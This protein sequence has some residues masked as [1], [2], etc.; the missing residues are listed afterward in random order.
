MKN[1]LLRGNAI[2][3][4]YRYFGFLGISVFFS[5][6]ITLSSSNITPDIRDKEIIKKYQAILLDDPSNLNAHFN[7]GILYYKN[8][9]FDEATREFKKVLEINPNDA[10]AY[11]NLGNSYNKKAQYDDA[12]K[13]YKKSLVDSPT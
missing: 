8:A 6:Q 12:I 3:R 11:Y 9:H 7:L 13:A 2:T 5:F 1:L 4:R 10:E